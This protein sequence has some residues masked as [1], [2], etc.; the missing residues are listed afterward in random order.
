MEGEEIKANL[1]I[2]E[3]ELKNGLLLGGR[4][5][6]KAV[7]RESTVG[8]MLAAGEETDDDAAAGALMIALQLQRIGE[9][10][11]PF[12]KALLDKLSNTDMELLE[13]ADAELNRRAR[14]DRPAPQPGG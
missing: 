3:V 5:Q 11:G 12:D 1:K 10:E 4:P 6:T 7:L 13:Q 8:D 14:E 9:I 2:I